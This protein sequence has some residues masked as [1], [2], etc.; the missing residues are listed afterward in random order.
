[1]KI[2]IEASFIAEN[3]GGGKEQ[4]LLNL[5]AGFRDL[6]C[7]NQFIIFGRE[8][9]YG[10]FKEIDSNINFISIKL[11]SKLT[12]RMRGRLIF[13]TF[14]LPHY[15]KKHK[16]DLVFFPSFFIGFARFKVPVVSIPHDIQFKSNPEILKKTPPKV[17]DFLYGNGFKHSEK[18]IAI[19]EFDKDEI[20]KHYP[21]C[22]DKVVR[23]Y[24]PI[25]FNEATI[26]SCMANGRQTERYI[27]AN[28]LSYGHKNLKTLLQAFNEIK[29]NVNHN[30]RIS[31]K[32]YIS[33][34]ETQ[35][36]MD[37]LL[38]EGRLVLYNYLDRND[39]YYVLQ[40]ADLFVN[41]SSF[42]GFGM[43]AVEAM[44]AK[45]PCVLADNSAVK[46]VTKGLANYYSPAK[47]VD[48][49]AE[50]MLSALGKE[51]KEKQLHEAKEAISSS[52][53]YKI[54]AK[55]YMRLF[56]ELWRSACTSS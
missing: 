25:I 8:K 2:G 46:E 52:Y 53:D 11:W 9:T 5:L 40:G 1:M 37:L 34:K 47:D 19:S 14:I 56:D 7:L 45:V 36:L 33:D 35:L 20:S 38:E 26:N 44:F 13:R 32:T 30:L 39:F 21:D 51:R 31:G 18:I 23:I 29:N 43:S 48:A 3:Y 42:E 16:V 41:P 49:L 54:I 10:K 55:D 6:G 24:N 28:N 12:E 22:A 50:A 15:V 17:L 4:V 27:F